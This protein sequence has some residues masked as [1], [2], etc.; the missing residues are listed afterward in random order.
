M[1][2]LQYKLANL[3]DVLV[4]KNDYVFTL[5]MRLTNSSARN[6]LQIGAIVT[7]YIGDEKPVVEVVQND[8]D[9]LL[10]ILKP[11]V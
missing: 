3:G 6:T 4:L 1:T 5:L 9:Y 7:D 11:K 10:I 8:D 2:E